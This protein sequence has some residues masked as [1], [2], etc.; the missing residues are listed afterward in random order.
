MLWLL[1]QTLWK[2][3]CSVHFP[4]WPQDAGVGMHN[5]RKLS[6]VQLC[7]SNLS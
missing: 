5:M 1:V 6:C 4:D 3:A 2:V 7:T